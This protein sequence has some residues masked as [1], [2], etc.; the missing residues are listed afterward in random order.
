MSKQT[1]PIY[2]SCQHKSICEH[3]ATIGTYSWEHGQ[4]DVN[5]NKPVRVFCGRHKPGLHRG[6]N[7]RNFKLAVNL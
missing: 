3:D 2:Q 6:Q 4:T 5:L 7:L 1:K